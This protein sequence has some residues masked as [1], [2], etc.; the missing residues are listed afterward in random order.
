MKRSNVI[1]DINAMSFLVTIPDKCLTQCANMILYLEKSSECLSSSSTAATN[2]HE[3]WM[4]YPFSE[5]TF[6]LV[7]EVSSN[8]QIPE[9][10]YLF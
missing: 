7:S 1:Y 9:S 5:V 3:I 10:K 6:L 4:S 8:S 2:S